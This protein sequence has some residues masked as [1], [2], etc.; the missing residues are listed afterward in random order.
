VAGEVA[1]ILREHRHEL[2]DEQFQAELAAAYADRP[3]CQPPVPPAQL[4]LATILR[5]CPL[6]VYGLGVLP[7]ARPVREPLMWTCVDR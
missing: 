2:F 1:C 5:A 7:P 4:A 6:R 3:K